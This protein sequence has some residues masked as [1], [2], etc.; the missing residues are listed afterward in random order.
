MHSIVG[1]AG[2]RKLNWLKIIHCER[3]PHSSSNE[4]THI[5]S[6]RLGRIFCFVAD[7]PFT[8]D[9]LP[10]MTAAIHNSKIFNVRSLIGNFHDQRE[11]NLFK[12]V[13]STRAAKKSEN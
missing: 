11:V 13:M 8:T 3:C 12:M 7:F 1:V 9:P 10:V 5:Y 2:H 6:R 4:C